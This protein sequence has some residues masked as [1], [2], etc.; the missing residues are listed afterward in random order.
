MLFLH[1]SNDFEQQ[2]V[3]RFLNRFKGRVSKCF[4]FADGRD[5]IYYKT[6]KSGILDDIG[7]FYFDRD[8]KTKEITTTFENGKVKQPYFDRVWQYYKDEFETKVFQFKEELFDLW[9]PFLLPGK[10]EHIPRESLL[11]ALRSNYERAMYFRVKSFLGKYS[12]EVS[13]LD[14]E[15]DYE[16]LES[17]KMEKKNVEKLEKEDGISYIFDDCIANLEFQESMGNK[18]ISDAYK[19]AKVALNQALF[20]SDTT[21]VSQNQLRLIAD[22]LN[23]L[24]KIIP[25]KLD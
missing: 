9:L 7:G 12:E 14:A 21:M 23:Y 8:S 5:Y 13:G 2:D 20:A 17:L 22:K 1:R 4:L 25:G 10:P 15:K 16:T 3:N 11:N 6:Q 24:V 19:E 18:F